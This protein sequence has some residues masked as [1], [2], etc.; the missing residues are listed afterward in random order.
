MNLTSEKERRER[1]IFKAIGEILKGNPLT[2]FSKP[3][4][5]KRTPLACNLAVVDAFILKYR[6]LFLAGRYAGYTVK[7]EHRARLK[8]DA[9][10]THSLDG[11]PEE[12]KGYENGCQVTFISDGTVSVY[13]KPIYWSDRLKKWLYESGRTFSSKII[14]WRYADPLPEPYSGEYGEDVK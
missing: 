8:K 14:A 7:K 1:E 3:M 6:Y 2:C 9:E 13:P 4:I 5:D 11:L 10:W 12:K